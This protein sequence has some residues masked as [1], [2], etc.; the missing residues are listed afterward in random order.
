M[1]RRDAVIIGA[2]P[3]GLSAAVYARRAGLSTL[4]LERGMH[5]GQIC[6]TSEIENYPAMEKIGGMALADMFRVQA[7]SFGAEFRPCDVKGL[8]LDGELAV[9]TSVGDFEAG[10]I[11]IASGASY[12][13]AGFKGEAEMIGRGVSF[14]AV[15][16]APLYGGAEVAVVGGGSSAV[17]EASYLARFA[18][19]V[20]VVHRRGEF[21]APR[22]EVD[23]MLADKKIVP[24]MDSTIEE[25]RGDGMLTSAVVKDA[26]TG[27]TRELPVEG[28]FVCV[29]MTPN[30]SFL[31]DISRIETTEGGW[32]KTDEVMRT[33]VDGVF[34]AGDVREK[35]LRQVVTAAADG[36]IAGTAAY[37]H[38]ARPYYSSGGIR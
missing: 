17:S 18:S 27:E 3:A 2:G 8:S 9:Q 26:R 34:A 31:G 13:R 22:R 10:A 5:G 28:V 36:A 14:C 25:V 33:S 24:I 11:I 1:E 7:D 29:G 20:Y 6:S 15:C 19:R 32:I 16:D 38:I 4:V 12:R 23:V 21:R 30:T 35:Y 37:E